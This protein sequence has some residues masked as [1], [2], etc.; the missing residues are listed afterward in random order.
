MAEVIGRMEMDLTITLRITESEA[1]ALDALA[2]YGDNAFVK[3]FYEKLGEAYMRKHENGLRL[4]LTT[5]RS[6]MPGVLGRA[7]RARNAFAG[8]EK[9]APPPE[10]NR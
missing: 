2:G 9:P 7:D 3:A 4:F 8:I 6:L 10:P 1:R 5:V